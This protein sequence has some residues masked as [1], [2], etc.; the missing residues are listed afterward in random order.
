MRGEREI[1]R[2]AQDDRW[3]D[4]VGAPAWLLPSPIEQELPAAQDAP[5]EVLD[6]LAT[7]LRVRGGRREERE[8]LLFLLVRRGAAQ[9]RQVRV[10]DDFFVRG[11][12]RQ[13]LLDPVARLLELLVDGV[14]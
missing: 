13:Q 12:R 5:V 1:L 6:H 11:V 7:L 3:A 4:D 14:A 8:D 2:C 9:R 10:F